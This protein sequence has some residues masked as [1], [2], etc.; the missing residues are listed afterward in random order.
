MAHLLRARGSQSIERNGRG[1]AGRD[2]RCCCR[3]SCTFVD[4]SERGEL[5]S[6]PM[7]P[8]GNEERSMSIVLQMPVGNLESWP[9]AKACLF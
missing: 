1:R 8:F 2:R 5:G 4:L 6:Q 9:R 3:V 7:L